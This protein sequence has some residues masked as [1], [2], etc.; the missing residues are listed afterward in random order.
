MCCYACFTSAVLLVGVQVRLSTRDM[1]L[2]LRQ[3]QGGAVQAAAALTKLSEQ[4]QHLQKQL[5]GSQELIAALQGLAAKQF[6][7]RREHCEIQTH[8][9]SVGLLWVALGFP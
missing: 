6:Q 5:D 7:V 4:Q 2:P 1:K 3:A 9:D 8:C